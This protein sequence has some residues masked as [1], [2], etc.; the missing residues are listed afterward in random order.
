MH[1]ELRGSGRPIMACIFAL[2]EEVG[3][4]EDGEISVQQPGGQLPHPS[5]LCNTNQMQS[6]VFQV[7]V[8]CLRFRPKVIDQSHAS[9][10]LVFIPRVYGPY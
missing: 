1:D 9:A 3:P 10:K 7:N 8:P 5:S 6:Y 4:T 2:Y